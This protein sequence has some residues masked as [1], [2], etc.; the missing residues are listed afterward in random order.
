M[1]TYLLLILR[2]PSIA[3]LFLPYTPY[4]SPWATVSTKWDH[5]LVLLGGSF[6]LSIPILIAQTRLF[7]KRPFSKGERAIYRGSPARRWPQDSHIW[8]SASGNRD[9]ARRTSR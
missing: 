9:S 8:D 5:G 7:L 3:L 4:T 6:F 1:R 2:I